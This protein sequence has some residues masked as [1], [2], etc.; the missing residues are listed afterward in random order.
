M[1]QLF[2]SLQVDGIATA[3]AGTARSSATA[4]AGTARST[5]VQT[6]LSDPA[7]FFA[8]H[9]AV[10]MQQRS[11]TALKLSSNAVERVLHE[12]CM[13][14]DVLGHHSRIRPTRTMHENEH[15]QGKEKH[16]KPDTNNR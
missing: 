10:E 11:V 5:P 15:V 2:C 7:S 16:A 14:R 6:L 9:N 13:K 4:D 3:D 8:W 1:S 12:V